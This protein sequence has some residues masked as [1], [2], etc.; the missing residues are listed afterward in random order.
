MKKKTKKIT[1]GGLVF[2][3]F[4]AG[5]S[6]GLEDRD[7]D[8]KCGG[9]ERWKQKVVID[10]SA[11]EVHTTPKPTTIQA[12]NSIPTDTIKIGKETVRQ[13][14]EK[15]VYTLTNCFISKAFVESDNDIHLA[16]EDGA[17]HHMV[18]EIPDPKCSD[19]KKSDFYTDFKTARKTFLKYQNV[20]D[21][22]RFN[23][24][25]VLF[26]DKKHPKPPVGNADNNIELHPVI[27]LTVADNF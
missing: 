11:G 1:I 12:L 2:A 15:Q 18:A 21:H 6:A 4:F 10:D 16:I 19:A 27:K 17:G 26:I 5:A 24:T 7:K 22:H 25:G 20:Y 13:P 8:E 23:I 3:L 14:I 9:E